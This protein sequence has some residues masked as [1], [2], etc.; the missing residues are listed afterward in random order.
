[1]EK[2]IRHRLP[3]LQGDP[4]RTAGGVVV[5]LVAQDRLRACALG[6]IVECLREKQGLTQSELAFRS[7]V[8]QSTLSRIEIGQRDVGVGTLRRIAAALCASTGELYDRL[9]TVLRL[10]ER[11]AEAVRPGAFHLVALHAIEGSL[12]LMRF[13]VRAAP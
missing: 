3:Q 4:D 9:Y 2:L 8:S 6:A 13:V 5:D 7:G 12:G 11:A 10:A 1:M